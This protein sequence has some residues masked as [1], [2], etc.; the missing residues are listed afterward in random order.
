MSDYLKPLYMENEFIIHNTQD[1]PEMLKNAPPLQA[2]EEYVSYDVE[3]LFTNVPIVE[4]I[5]YI[6]KEIYE[7]GKL[8]IICTQLIMKRLLLKLTTESTFMFQSQFY[9]QTDGCTMGGPLSVTFSN[10]CLTKMENEKVKIARP[11][12]YKRFVDDVFNIRKKGVTDTLLKSL[13]SFHPKLKFTVEVNPDKFLDT[14]IENNHGNI[15]TSVFRKPSSLPTHWTS[16]VPKRYKRNAI[17]GELYRALKISSDFNFEKRAIT[18]KYVN[19]GYPIKFIHSV[20]RQFNE[21]RQKSMELDEM[22]I[23]DNLFEE[24]PPL[25]LLEIPYCSKN[26]ELAKHFLKRLTWFTKSRFDFLV[27][28]KTRKVRQ[29]FTLKDKNPYPSCKVYYGKCDQCNVTYVGETHRNVKTRWA[30]HGN[31]KKNSA[32]SKHIKENIDHTFS[33]KI[34]CSA[35]VRRRERENLEASFIGLLKP[36]LNEKDEFPKILT[37]FRNGVT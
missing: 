9:K 22:I 8:P 7:E 34:I 14:K 11:K 23:P 30:E 25:V 17:N 19:A 26:E 3:S 31:P 6:L 18:K 24:K 29:L 2:D 28:W 35:P 27:V 1:F 33:W 32:P 12:F 36:S 10:I 5:D 15:T 21:K 13:N 16:K 37:L 4:T 20:F